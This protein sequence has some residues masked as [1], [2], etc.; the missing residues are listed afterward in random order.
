MHAFRNPELSNSRLEGGAVGPVS[1]QIKVGVRLML[2]DPRE[3]VQQWNNP[4]AHIYARKSDDRRML[5]RD[6]GRGGALKRP[7]AT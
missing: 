7:S 5:K 6:R 2:E 4:L 1:N 3:R